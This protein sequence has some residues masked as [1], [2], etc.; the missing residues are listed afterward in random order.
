MTAFRY[1]DEPGTRAHELGDKVDPAEAQDRLDELMELQAEISREIN[2]G[3][4]GRTLRVLVEEDGEEPGEMRGRSYR[5]APEIDGSVLIARGAAGS[6]PARGRFA[7][8][9]VQEA[10]EHDLRGMPH[11]G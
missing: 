7:D 11:D 1:W 10:L 9:L 4:V 2:E 5:D 8:V 3:F 6:C